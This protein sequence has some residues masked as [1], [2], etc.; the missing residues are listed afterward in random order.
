MTIAVLPLNAAEG[1][2]PQLGRQ[3]SAFVGEQL[4]AHA[5]ADVQSISYLTQIEQQGQQRT[6][7]VNLSDGMLET[8]QLDELFQQTGVDLAMDGMLK[9]TG[10]GEATEYEVTIR[11]TRKEN[12]K[13]EEETYT[14]S[15]SG[16]FTT[17]HT[18]V[19]RLAEKGGI[20]LPEALAGESME[21]GTDDA[22]AFVLFLE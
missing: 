12:R 11:F 18:I 19:K 8:E 3:I 14:F 1:A 10:E 5:E 17:L 21:F 20:A 16:I 7:F 6:A 4:R 22:H 9:S 2:K 13:A 15:E